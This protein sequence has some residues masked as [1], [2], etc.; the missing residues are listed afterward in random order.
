M[1]TLPAVYD[2][3]VDE[4]T[5]GQLAVLAELR[6]RLDGFPGATSV[7]DLYAAELVANVRDDEGDET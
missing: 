4:M 2:S 5:L 1:T 6:G 7:V 3:D